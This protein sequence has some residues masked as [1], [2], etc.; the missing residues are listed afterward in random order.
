MSLP[1]KALQT[2]QLGFNELYVSYPLVV[3]LLRPG[4]IW[5]RDLDFVATALT[6]AWGSLGPTKGING[7]REILHSPVSTGVSCLS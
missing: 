2:Q 7:D 5:M 3:L 4:C 1:L 6:V